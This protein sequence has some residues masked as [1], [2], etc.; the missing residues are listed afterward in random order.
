[1][2]LIEIVNMIKMKEHLQVWSIM[3][4]IKKQDQ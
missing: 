4:L 1:M 2:K 3:F